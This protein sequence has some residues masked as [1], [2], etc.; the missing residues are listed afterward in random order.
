MAGSQHRA[1][2][3][4][5]RR[6]TLRRRWSFHVFNGS[7]GSRV[8]GGEGEEGVDLVESSNAIV[9]HSKVSLKLGYSG[10]EVEVLG[11][12]CRR[13]RFAGGAGRI[14]GLFPEGGLQVGLVEYREF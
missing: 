7:G 1:L 12:R 9:G 13:K 11:I 4:I 8:R 10:T 6:R 3:D 5:W 14:V 2:V